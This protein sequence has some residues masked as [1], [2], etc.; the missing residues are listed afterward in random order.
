MLAF[1]KFD[2]L[3]TPYI[4]SF[5]YFF[6]AIIIPFIIIYFFKKNLRINSL[7]L[8]LYMLV[9][10]LICELFLENFLRI[11]HGLF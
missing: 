3:I 11:F 10:F 5:V 9:A 7:R 4:I 2:I 8:R 6:G 1:F